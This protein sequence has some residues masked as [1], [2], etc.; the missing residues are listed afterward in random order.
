MLVMSVFSCQSRL[1]C[2]VLSST[3]LYR[4][5]SNIPPFFTNS[6]TPPSKDDHVDPFVPS[7]STPPQSRLANIPEHAIGIS[8]KL[9]GRNVAADDGDDLIRDSSCTLD[10]ITEVSFDD[11]AY[12]VLE[13]SVMLHDIVLSPIRSSLWRTAHVQPQ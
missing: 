10:V 8:L 12:S 4:C 6:F 9:F 3:Y 1:F 5:D 13:G 11:L 7:R 2:S